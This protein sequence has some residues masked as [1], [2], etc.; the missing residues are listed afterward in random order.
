MWRRLRFCVLSVYESPAEPDG[1]GRLPLSSPLALPCGIEERLE[2]GLCRIS[3]E[4]DFDLEASALDIGRVDAGRI[5]EPAERHGAAERVTIGAR[6]HPADALA[7]APDRLVLI[8]PPPPVAQ[9]QRHQA[10]LHRVVAPAPPRA[11][12]RSY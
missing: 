7:V 1:C 2:A 6:R 12:A 10:A 9:H 5:L 3:R 11:S 4:R 8:E